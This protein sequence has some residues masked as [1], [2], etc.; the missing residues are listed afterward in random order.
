MA[1]INAQ[2]LEAVN[3]MRSELTNHERGE[4]GDISE[5]RGEIKTVKDDIV[6][7]RV[8]LSEWRFAAEQRHNEAMAA[9]DRRHSALIQSL[10]A[11]QDDVNS[12]RKAFLVKEGKPDYDGHHADHNIREQRGSMVMQ[13]I[14]EGAGNLVKLAMASGAVW[15]LYQVWEAL[16]KG[17]K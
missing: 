12:M 10:S 11:Y 2:V 4:E 17:P 3:Q 16:H 5:I 6:Q 15:F 8:D 13:W 7:I 14:R 1:D 9:S